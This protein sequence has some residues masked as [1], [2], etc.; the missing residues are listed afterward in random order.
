MTNMMDQIAEADRLAEKCKCRLGVLAEHFEQLSNEEH[1]LAFDDHVLWAMGIKKILTDT[2]KDLS[3]VNT[4]TFGLH[5][6]LKLYSL[7]MEKVE[8]ENKYRKSIGIDT[9]LEVPT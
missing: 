5:D 2:M 7:D 3:G 4:L 1:E 9:A 6:D 8:N